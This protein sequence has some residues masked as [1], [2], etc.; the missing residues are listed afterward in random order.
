MIKTLRI[1]KGLWRS[2][3]PFYFILFFSWTAAFFSSLSL[4]AL[5]TFLFSFLLLLRHSFVYF[6]CTRVA[7]IYIFWYILNYWFWDSFWICNLVY[8][9]YAT[10]TFLPEIPIPSTH[11]VTESILFHC[12]SNCNLI[13]F[14]VGGRSGRLF[15]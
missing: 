7:P 12:L 6:L 2:S 4:L 11:I 5:M 3:S 14:R 9:V 15:W 1:K 8:T 13:S 10:L